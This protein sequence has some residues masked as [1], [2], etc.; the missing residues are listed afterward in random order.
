MTD[1]VSRRAEL[2]RRNAA[3]REQVEQM[4]SDL[5]RRTEGLREAH[6]AAAEVTGQATA[7]DGRVRASVDADGVLG[8]L[9]L[10]PSAFDRT[11]PE[12]LARTIA[13]VVRQATADAQARVAE[14]LAHFTEAGVDLPDLVPG[15]PSLRTPVPPQPSRSRR[16]DDVGP[17]TTYLQEA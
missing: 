4:L 10:A 1:P 11:T 15:A 13:E 5:Q 17:P 9:R 7:P 2:E 6:A 12:A 14:T 16:D 3:M 8:D